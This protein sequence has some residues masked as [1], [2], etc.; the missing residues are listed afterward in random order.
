MNNPPAFPPAPIWL[1]NCDA[2]PD[3]ESVGVQLLADDD[4]ADRAQYTAAFTFDHHAAMNARNYQA[5]EKTREA[6]TNNSRFY[7]TAPTASRIPS[8]ALHPWFYVHCVGIPNLERLAQSLQAPENWRQ[9]I[10]MAI[11]LDSIR[12][13]WYDVC[14]QTD[15][16][17]VRVT[18]TARVLRHHELEYSH[19]IFL[20]NG[21]IEFYHICEELFAYLGAHHTNWS[22]GP[23]RRGRLTGGRSRLRV[24]R[25]D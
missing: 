25:G 7:L 1:L 6:T 18:T 17:E 15:D 14:N 8:N 12:E 10:D 23:L 24:H 2:F 21:R 16:P 5:I 9:R 13:D 11:Q 22:A 20:V 3:D 19:F 4:G